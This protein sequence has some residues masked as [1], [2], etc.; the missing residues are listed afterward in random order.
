[1]SLR[2]KPPRHRATYIAPP[3]LE[4]ET[5]PHRFE[6]LDVASTKGYTGVL[7]RDHVGGQDYPFDHAEIAVWAIPKLRSGETLLGYPSGLFDAFLTG[8]AYYPE[9]LT[10]VRSTT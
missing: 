10:D 7:L 3:D 6:I 5:H 2:R 9:S 8:A 4:P 1:M